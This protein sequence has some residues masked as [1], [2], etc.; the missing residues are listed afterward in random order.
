MYVSSANEAWALDAGTGRE[1]GAISSRVRRVRQEMLL[2]VS[3]VAVPGSA[4][5]LFDRLTAYLLKRASILK[6]PGSQRAIE[7]IQRLLKP[8]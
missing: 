4:L 5:R 2:L 7:V 1:F 6:L 3:T 8:G